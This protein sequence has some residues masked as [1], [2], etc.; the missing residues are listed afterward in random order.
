MGLLGRIVKSAVGEAIEHTVREAVE[1]VT[2]RDDQSSTGQTPSGVTTPE[3]APSGSLSAAAEEAGLHDKAAFR[4]LLAARF[5]ELAVREDV[6]VSELGGDGKPYEFALFRGAA[7]PATTAVGLVVLVA[8]NRDNNRAYKGA[9]AAAQAAGVPFINFYL[10]MPNQPDF[11]EG[12][13]R[14]LMR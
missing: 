8:H 9:K 12:R 14:R 13:I 6:P 7:G 11:V 3:A 10:H 1:K 4:S 5:P 2:D